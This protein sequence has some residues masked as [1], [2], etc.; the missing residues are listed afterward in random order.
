MRQL[1]QRD[2]MEVFPPCSLCLYGTDPHLIPFNLACCG[3]L[4]IPFWW[5]EF[6]PYR[7]CRHLNKQIHILTIFM[8]SGIRYLNL[9]NS[10]LLV[11]NV[12]Q[13]LPD[14]VR[15]DREMFLSEKNKCLNCICDGWINPWGPKELEPTSLPE[16]RLEQREEELSD[17]ARNSILMK[18]VWGFLTRKA[19]WII[20]VSNNKV[21]DMK[22]IE[23][24]KLKQNQYNQTCSV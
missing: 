23:K 21:T 8:A 4:H 10:Q 11:D 6:S 13:S 20:K 9:T 1:Y 2:G 12:I 3:Q 15:E 5:Q 18:L 22:L 7:C 14:F 19:K 16:A 24:R 17:I